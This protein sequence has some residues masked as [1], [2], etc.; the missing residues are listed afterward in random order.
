M[1]KTKGVWRWKE[2]RTVAFCHFGYPLA[3]LLYRSCLFA[4]ASNAGT[5]CEISLL[6][7]QSNLPFYQ[8]LN[9]SNNFYSLT[10]A[11]RKSEEVEPKLDPLLCE[12]YALVFLKRHAGFL[13]HTAILWLSSPI[14]SYDASSC[15]NAPFSWYLNPLPTTITFHHL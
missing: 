3:P 10:G 11:G 14:K 2:K 15:D 13:C 8:A 4:P 1:G 9:W 5:T 6:G 12:L 7:S